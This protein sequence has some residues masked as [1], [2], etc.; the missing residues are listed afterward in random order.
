MDFDDFRRR[1]SAE[2]F[3]SWV[4]EAGLT[5]ETI[6]GFFPHGIPA[7]WA[8]AIAQSFRSVPVSEWPKV[9]HPPRVLHKRLRRAT[10]NSEMHADHRQAI[11]RSRPGDEAFRNAIGRY[12]QNELAKAVGISPATL[13]FYRNGRKVPKKVAD[14]VERLTGFKATAKNWPGGIHGTE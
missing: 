8:K 3:S 5:E 6:R 2:L 1:I 11:S 10:V 7:E 14:D 4:T 9:I 13:S 12:T